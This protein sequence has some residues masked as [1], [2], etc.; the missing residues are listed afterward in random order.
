[1]TVASLRPRPLA[2][3]TAGMLDAAPAL[4]VSDVTLDSRTARP[5]S[6]F[7]ACRGRTQHGLAFA[8]QA[9]ARGATAVLYEADAA[10][11]PALPPLGEDVYVARVPALSQRCGTIADRFFDAP[12]AQLAIAGLTGTNG[13][14]TSAWLLAQA[15][16]HCGREAAYTGTLGFGRPGALTDSGFT[17]PDVVSVHRQLAT[18]RGLG[19]DC[20]AMEVS[21]H[22]LDQDRVAGVRFHTAAFTNLTRDHLDY[23]GTM[24]AYFAAKRRLFAWPDL[25]VRVINVD[26]PWGAR[27]AALDDAARLVTTSRASSPATGE[28]VRA[29]AVAAT[30]RGL[31]VAVESS[32][33]AAPLAVP[34]I[35][36]FNVENVLTVLGILLAWDVPLATA[37]AALA[38]CTAPAGRMEVFG[39]A[40]GQPLAIVDYAHTP[41]AL[42]KALRACRAHCRGRL[43]VVFGCGGDR[44]RGKRPQ[45]GRIAEELADSI[46]VTDDN[47]RTEDPAVIV[48]EILAGLHAPQLAGVEHDRAAA[49]RRALEGAGEGDVVLVAGKG[50]ED[51]QICGTERR[52]FSD[53]AVLREALG[54]RP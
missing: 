17:T 10:D 29:R 13:K 46:L 21:S 37:A 19:A 24:E 7:L 34:L 44:D 39:G 42:A 35:G 52:W 5:G 32:W 8:P 48:G 33:G 14:T 9:V 51:Y 50:H 26:D 38:R 20:V 28:F 2:E 11:V 22:A 1:M 23:H 31:E 47:P 4:A 43:A 45:M 6:L 36:D 25:A 15:L 54:G 18:L 49:I 41:D 40:P 53:Q 30:A 27:L 12:S 16:Q 3:L